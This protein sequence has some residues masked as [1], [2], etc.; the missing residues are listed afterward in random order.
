MDTKKKLSWVSFSHSKL[1]NMPSYPRCNRASYNTLPWDGGSQRMRVCACGRSTHT[2]TSTQ[3][4]L[5]APYSTDRLRK[6]SPPPQHPPPVRFQLDRPRGHGDVLRRGWGRVVLKFLFANQLTCFFFHRFS[7]HLSAVM[8]FTRVH[9]HVRVS[10]RELSRIPHVC[11]ERLWKEFHGMIGFPCQGL[12]KLYILRN[13]LT[14]GR[15]LSVPFSC[16]ALDMQT[17]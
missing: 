15:S 17:S 3:V 5:A 11:G 12:D 1:Q 14:R 16:P 13:S 6:S 4:P 7:L 9:L 2:H 10:E 8:W